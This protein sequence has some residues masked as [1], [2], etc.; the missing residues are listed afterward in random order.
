MKYKNVYPILKIQKFEIK[1]IGS[2]F[3]IQKMKSI[4][5]IIKLNMIQPKTNNL[6]L[7]SL[8]NIIYNSI[9]NNSV[10]IN[11]NEV[12]IYFGSQIL[13]N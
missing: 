11:V 10:N 4:V 3:F 2:N 13:D 7:K 6:N 12:I 5:K 8:N 1:T 9:A